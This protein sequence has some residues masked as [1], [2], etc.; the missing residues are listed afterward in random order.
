MNNSKTKLNNEI[1]L[2]FHLNPNAYCYVAFGTGESTLLSAFRFLV[3]WMP[4]DIAILIFGFIEN[5]LRFLEM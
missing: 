4:S 2:I 5:L 3:I 1:I